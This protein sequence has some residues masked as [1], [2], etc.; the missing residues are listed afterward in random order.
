MDFFNLLCYIYVEN[1]NPRKDLM[2][3][4]SVENLVQFLNSLPL[5]QQTQIAESLLEEA[6]WEASIQAP[7]GKAFI[8]G[9]IEKTK[10]D[11]RE[12]RG[13]SLD[14]FLQKAEQYNIE[15]E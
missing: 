3:T 7:K 9:L 2:M 1:D 6:K 5:P 13:M 15:N 12:G 4:Q 8:E 11:A 14:E 10:R